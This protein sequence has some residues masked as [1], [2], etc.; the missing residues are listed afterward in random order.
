MTYN[1]GKGLAYKFLK[2]HVDYDGEGCLIWPFFK[3][4]TGYG[5]LGY[6]GKM[7]YAH[8]TMCELVN[9]PAPSDI[10][11]ASHTCGKGHLGCIDPRHLCWMTPSENKWEQSR[12]GTNRGSPYG[13]KGALNPDQVREIRASKEHRDL[14]AKRYG[15]STSA[16]RRVQYGVSYKSVV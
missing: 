4:P 12:H 16:I 8:R 13:P 15:L 5:M 2:D 7:L 9:G 6:L 10:H 3:L 11:E 1:R 14:L